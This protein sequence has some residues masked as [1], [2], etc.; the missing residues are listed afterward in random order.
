[1]VTGA[2]RGFGR[3]AAVCMLPIIV[4][5]QEGFP[6]DGTWR[7]EWGN[8]GSPANHV[9]IVMKWDGETVTGSINPGPNSID[10]DTAWLDASNWGVHIEA[11]AAD[12]D[13]IRIDGTLSDIGSRNRR[14]SGT[15]RVGD[16]EHAFDITRE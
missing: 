12:G 5:A 2:L 3:I 6:L 9:V 1:M 15:W 14:V 8:P 13:P 16:T 10:F 7:G 4:A 11:T